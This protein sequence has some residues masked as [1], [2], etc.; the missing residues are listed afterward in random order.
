MISTHACQLTIHELFERQV[1]RTAERIAISF[2]AKNMTYRELNER[3]NQVAH[4]LRSKCGIGSKPDMLVGI[5]VER[6]LEMS[7]GILGILKAGGAYVPLD[8]N[9]PDERLK[10]IIEDTSLKLIFI[11]SISKMEKWMRIFPDGEV[12]L[13]PL[14][15]NQEISTSSIENPTHTSIARDLCYVIYTSG[16]T[17]RPK[18]AMLEHAGVIN[19]L[20]YNNKT[21][22]ITDTDVFLQKTAFTFDASVLEL[23][24]PLLAGAR[25][26]FAIPEGHKDVHYLVK[27]LHEEKITILLIVPSLL[28]FIIEVLS[29]RKDLCD[30]LPLRIISAGG[31][32]LTRTLSQKTMK[33]LKNVT[34]Y[35]QYG[36]TEASI[37][38]SIFECSLHYQTGPD[39]ESIGKSFPNVS[40]FILNSSRRLLPIGV[41]GELYIGGIA[42]ARGYLNRPELTA[43]R[44][45]DHYFPELNQTMRLYRTGDLVRYREDGNIDCL[46]RMDYQVKIRG[47]RVELG[48]IETELMKFPKV[49]EAAVV[50][51]DRLGKENIQLVGFLI[52][53]KESKENKVSVVDEIKSFLRISLLEHMIPAHLIVLESMP[54]LTSGKLDRNALVALCSSVDIARSSSSHS[55]IPVA[56]VE[57]SIA[58]VWSEV[59]GIPLSS[60]R[61]EDDFFNLGGNSLLVLKCLSLFQSKL[62]KTLTF[63]EFYQF[64]TIENIGKLFERNENMEVPAKDGVSFV[65]KLSRKSL[66]DYSLPKLFLI[67]PVLGLATFYQGIASSLEKEFVVYGIN[68]PFFMEDRPYHCLEDLAAEYVRQVK[69][70]CPEG[71]FCFGGWSMGGILALEMTRQL[72]LEGLRVSFLLLLDSHYAPYYDRMD[73]N[74]LKMYSRSL[75]EYHAREIEGGS[76]PSDVLERVVDVSVHLQHLLLNYHPQKSLLNAIPRVLVLK[77]QGYS[78]LLHQQQ[79]Q[80]I[81]WNYKNLLN[82]VNSFFSPSQTIFFEDLR[83]GHDELFT[84]MYLPLLNQTLGK[85]LHL[86]VTNPGKQT[87]EGQEEASSS[88]CRLISLSLSPYQNQCIRQEQQ[89]DSSRYEKDIHIFPSANEDLAKDENIEMP[90]YQSLSGFLHGL[91]SLTSTN[92]T[93]DFFQLLKIIFRSC[94]SNIVTCTLSVMKYLLLLRIL[95]TVNLALLGAFVLDD[96]IFQLVGGISSSFVLPFTNYVNLALSRNSL[97][98]ILNTLMALFLCFFLTIGISLFVYGGVVGSVSY[99]FRS[100]PDIN[101][102]DEDGVNSVASEWITLAHIHLIGVL[103]LLLNFVFE[104]FYLCLFQRGKVSLGNVIETVSL[105]VIVVLF[106]E[107]GELRAFELGFSLCIGHYLKLLFYCVDS[108]WRDRVISSY[109]SIAFSSLTTSA[110]VRD[111]FRSS[112]TLCQVYFKELKF[113]WLTPFFMFS[114]VCILTFL[115]GSSSSSSSSFVHSSSN[116]ASNI[117]IALRLGVYAVI[118]SCFR[119]VNLPGVLLISSSN[120]F[121][122]RMIQVH[123]GQFHNL[124]KARVFL[125]ACSFTLSTCLALILWNLTGKELSLLFLSPELI[126]QAARSSFYSTVRSL[127]YYLIGLG[128]FTSLFSPIMSFLFQS[129][130]Y[131][132]VMRISFVVYLLLGNVMILGTFFGMNEDGF[133]CIR[134]IVGEL[135]GVGGLAFFL[136]LVYWLRI[137]H[138]ES[139]RENHQ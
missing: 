34:V 61:A 28:N 18:G 32:I 82:G 45:I 91:I 94:Q 51:S 55:R 115:I 77:C 118:Q 73:L 36:P 63:A 127:S 112:W 59:L 30:S 24:C 80:Q 8:P 125:L 138:W 11:E 69:L 74:E 31:E 114:N 42:L 119:V 7:I 40:H 49:K 65:I 105:L 14:M 58:V 129:L 123:V 20:L 52:L 16:S 121:L 98:E 104:P 83:C 57:L 93:I 53:E 87:Y 4:F 100:S 111:T 124:L 17:G 75:F 47:F 109:F 86:S 85:L 128:V 107:F 90:T 101:D 66:D 116:H 72:E 56:G 131:P 54:Y 26:I 97:R 44:F 126:P 117:E 27:M 25:L 120:G 137:V 41:V 23:L 78:P 37:D 122:M 79:Y 22:R 130:E 88:P 71:P 12:S 96:V 43:D 50:V 67:H 15:E 70:V 48:E 99:L 102:D 10:F 35:N 2:E 46:G 106:K 6:S 33:L 39:R 133:D 136:L 60:L 21:Y 19:C 110:D 29:S 132:A 92:S 1:T 62:H 108:M 103:P 64:P 13:V 89:L 134:T 95:S 139:L 5:G 9:Y 68:Y 113:H 81:F 76:C 135:F 38:S 3:S 84:P